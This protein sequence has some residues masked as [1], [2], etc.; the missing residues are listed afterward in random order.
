MLASLE[1]APASSILFQ[2]LLGVRSLGCR[3]L[4]NAGFVDVFERLQLLALK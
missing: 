2:E 4:A 1:C 3:D